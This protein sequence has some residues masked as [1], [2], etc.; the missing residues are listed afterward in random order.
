M[1]EWIE[2]QSLR[3]EVGR[4]EFRFQ[5]GPLFVVMFSAVATLL[6]QRYVWTA[7]ISLNTVS[8]SASG[9]EHTSSPKCNRR[10]MLFGRIGVFFYL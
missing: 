9:R 10:P 2:W 5:E 3:Q 7:G 4:N 1:D 8:G 6:V